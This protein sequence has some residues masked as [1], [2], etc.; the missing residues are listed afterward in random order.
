MEDDKE[1]RNSLMEDVTELEGNAFFAIAFLLCLSVIFLINRLIKKRN[2]GTISE[3]D[4]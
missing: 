3:E 4:R 1:K 2:Q